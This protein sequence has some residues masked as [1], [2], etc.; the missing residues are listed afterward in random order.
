MGTTGHS[1]L[2]V[3][4]DE[5]SRNL[6]QEVLTKAGYRVEV[7]ASAE[8]AFAILKERKF[9]LVLSDIRMLE[10]SGLDLLREIKKSNHQSVVVLM[11]GFGSMEGAIEALKEGAFDYISK[12]FKMD[13][14]IQLIARAAKQADQLKGRVDE[15][16]HLSPIQTQSLIGKSPK[17]VDVYKTLA[18]AAL[19][20]SH[21]FISG[22]A[23]TGKAL[24]ARAIHDHSTRSHHAFIKLSCEGDLSGLEK[25]IIE[26]SHGTLLLEDLD[27]LSASN[28]LKLLRVLESPGYSGHDVR[29]ISLSRVN[30]HVLQKNFRTDLFLILNVISMDLPPL[31]ERLEDLPDLVGS[32]LAKH[33]FKNKKSISHLSESAMDRLKS[34]P[35]KGNVRELEHTIE[36]AVALSNS[37]VL[38]PEDFSN[39]LEVEVANVGVNAMALGDA[40]TSLEEMERSHI[41][42][43]LQDTKFNKSKA[44]EVLG[45]DRATLYRK[46]KTY[47]ID[48]KGPA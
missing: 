16:A 24:V 22:E 27:L 29:I 44:S 23:G 21:V 38:E 28:Q 13:E 43:V 30:S 10:M 19:S 3:D 45:I 25:S 7:A 1:L 42:K 31:R 2:V 41:L 12:P 46:A 18:R 47:G 26:A 37:T 5:V 48:L 11:T 4:D 34:Y 40:R 32:F 35:W 33:S 36:R 8:A 20:N 14:L 39:L 6:L 9:P 15:P 17:I